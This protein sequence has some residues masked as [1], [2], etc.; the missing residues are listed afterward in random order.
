[1]PDEKDDYIYRGSGKCHRCGEQV[2]YFRKVHWEGSGQGPS[3]R[4]RVL[5]AGKL[6]AHRANCHDL[7]KDKAARHQPSSVARDQGV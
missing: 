5:N 1:M 2:D 4:W 3:F 7:S 6:T